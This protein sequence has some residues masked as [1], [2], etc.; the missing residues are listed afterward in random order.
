MLWNL[1]EYADK[2]TASSRGFSIAIPSLEIMKNLWEP[3]EQSIA[4]PPGYQL[5]LSKPND[6]CSL[7]LALSSTIHEIELLQDR[8]RPGS[9]QQASISRLME[10]SHRIV[11]CYSKTLRQRCLDR[12]KIISSLSS[13][14]MSIQSHDLHGAS[15]CLVPW[16]ELISALIA[17]LNPSDTED[18]QISLARSLVFTRQLNQFKLRAS[19]ALDQMASNL[20]KQVTSA[21]W[22]KF[23]PDFQNAAK[24]Y[25]LSIKGRFTLPND[26]ESQLTMTTLE[27]VQPFVTD[28]MQKAYMKP[29]DP[30]RSFSEDDQEVEPSAKR[31]KI[32]RRPTS[33]AQNESL[34]DWDLRD[35]VLEDDD[36]IRLQALGGLNR[37]QAAQLDE[38]E[39]IEFLTEYQTF[40]CALILYKITGKWQPA[41]NQCNICQVQEGAVIT[42]GTGPCDPTQS[43]C[44]KDFSAFHE[45]LRTLLGSPLLKNSKEVRI[46]CIQAIGRLMNHLI[47]VKH[48]NLRAS[49]LGSYCITAMQSSVREVRLSATHALMPYLKSF[50]PNRMGYVNRS[51]I[52]ELLKMIDKRSNLPLQETVLVFWGLIGRMGEETELNIAL[53]ELANGLGHPH[54]MICATAFQ[55]IHYTAIKLNR[56][57]IDLFLPYWRSIAPSMIRDILQ[58]PQKVQQLASLIGLKGGV[59][60][61]LVMTEVETIPLLAVTKEHAI[62]ER[63]AQAR[64]VNSVQDLV[65][66]SGTILRSVLTR[67]LLECGG[68]LRVAESLLQETISNLNGRFVDIL[69][70]ESILT[71]CEVLKIAGDGTETEKV[72]ALLS[73]R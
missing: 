5:S 71:A 1:E 26:V 68:S 46:L 54:P 29:L 30:K 10:A 18:V 16:L 19:D 73:R 28:L 58:R 41:H 33:K 37:D 39:A 2:N 60:E 7:A 17:L 15:F 14:L 13:T 4:L 42:D 59:D 9:S 67:I 61:L 21:R 40:P 43:G 11:D 12:R 55:E 56:R 63:I 57:P 32:G 48:L 6:I 64:G 62:L 23:N 52:F 65:T 47:D 44:Q 51:T 31:L 35:L 49:P 36:S 20:I 50:L 34:V 72:C 70:V 69:R 25:L 27:R 24:L 3:L 45:S 22:S 53:L 38:I 8:S 66:G